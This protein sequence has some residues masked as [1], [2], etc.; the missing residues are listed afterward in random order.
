MRPTC[1]IIVASLDPPAKEEKQ[2]AKKDMKETSSFF[3]E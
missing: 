1:R 3:L 2:L